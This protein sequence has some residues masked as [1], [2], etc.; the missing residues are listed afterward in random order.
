MGTLIVLEGTDG[1]GKSTQLRLL[2]ERLRA[3]GRAFRQLRFPQYDQPSSA[4]IRMYLEGQFGEDPAA[5][6][7][8]AASTFYAVDRYASFVRDWGAYYREGGLLV[9]D[10]YATS[11]AIHQG[12]KVPPA[13][14]PAFLAWLWDLEYRKMGLPRPDRVFWLDMPPRWSRELLARRR[15]TG[16]GSDIHERDGDYLARCYETAREAAASDG[17]TA[18]PAVE[19]GA[20]RSP[21]AIAE[22]IYRHVRHCLE[23]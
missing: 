18:V 2:T 19:H 17:W 12:V 8:Y 5:V 3:E 23:G 22:E 1:A 16:G 6:N 13:E 10:R 9:A 4:L 14:R 11:N 7:G 15:A 21:E 20:L